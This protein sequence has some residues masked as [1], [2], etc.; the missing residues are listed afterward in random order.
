VI[1]ARI[2]AD[3]VGPWGKRI[4]TFVLTYPRFIHAELMTHRVFTRN[5]ASSRA[6]PVNKMIEAV[7]ANP[8]MPVEWGTAK[9]GMQAGPALQGEEARGAAETWRAAMR[10]AVGFTHELLTRGV[11]KQI[12]NR[13]IEPFSHITTLVTA[14]EW[15]NFFALRAHADAQ[16]E[17]QDLAWYPMLDAF[18]ESVPTP[19]AAGEWHVPFGDRMPPELSEPERLRVATARCARISYLTFEGEINVADDFRLHD[20][21]RDAGHWSPFEHCARAMDAPG[22]SGNFHGW[23]QY[24]KLFPAENRSGVD[25]RELRD[26]RPPRRE[27]SW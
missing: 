3:S 6:I 14:T 11:H 25:L 8:A 4:T 13:L 22:W 2:I 5:A 19:L 12:A 27:Q 10:S 24:R 20:R 16:P 21:L 17:F 26:N 23:E 1:E 18:L 9:S 7:L 15:E